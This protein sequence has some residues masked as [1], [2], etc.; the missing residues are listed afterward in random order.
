[1]DN[2]L[3]LRTQKDKSAKNDKT[4]ARNLVHPN[5]IQEI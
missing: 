1:M 4:K 2:Q 3:H 5:Q